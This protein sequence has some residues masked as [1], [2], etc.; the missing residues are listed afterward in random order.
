[1]WDLTNAGNGHLR[2]TLD[3][4][5]DLNFRLT[6]GSSNNLVSGGTSSTGQWYNILSLVC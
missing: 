6:A 2:L 4:V 1:M 5:P 3:S